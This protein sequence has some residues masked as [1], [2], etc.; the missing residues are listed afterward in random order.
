MNR[1]DERAL[2]ALKRLIE[3]KPTNLAV[4]AK[5]SAGFRIITVSNVAAEAGVSR[6]NFASSSSRY[7][8]V[9]HAIMEAR[10]TE[11]RLSA[12][13]NLE[14]ARKEI[15]RLR[16]QLHDSDIQNASL[17]LEV[18]RLRRSN[19]RISSEKVVEFR[20]DRRKRPR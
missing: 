10:K 12:H 8:D 16:K 2:E 9:H 5:M 20:Q 1:P 3:G 13:D 19:G 14:M 4:K 17:Q 18:N 15:T 6:N 11:N 7:P